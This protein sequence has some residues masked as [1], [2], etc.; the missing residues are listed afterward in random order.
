MPFV[1]V[2]TLSD[3]SPDYG[4]AV[5]VQGRTLALFQSNGVCYAIDDACPHKGLPLSPGRTAGTDVICPWHMARFDLPSGAPLSPPAKSPVRTY[6]V[7]VVG[8]DIEV[9]LP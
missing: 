5:V 4:K 9:E 8:E 2:A 1:K 3:L 6:T 7:R